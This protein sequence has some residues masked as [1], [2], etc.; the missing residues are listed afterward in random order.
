MVWARKVCVCV[1]V[2]LNRAGRRLQEP[3]IHQKQPSLCY[4]RSDIKCTTWAECSF[5]K[6][7]AA[8][9]VSS[10]SPSS[11]TSS[12]K[13]T[14]SSR[15]G[16]NLQR[17]IEYQEHISVKICV[18]LSAG[19]IQTKFPIRCLYLGRQ[20]SRVRQKS[21]LYWVRTFYWLLL[22]FLLCVCVWFFSL[23]QIPDGTATTVQSSRTDHAHVAHSVSWDKTRDHS[24][25]EY[26]TFSGLFDKN[27]KSVN[28]SRFLLPI[29]LI[30]CL[31]WSR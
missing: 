2:T 10:D 28:S 20:G 8:F 7:L 1:C 16:T 26:V 14:M 31:N 18:Y 13:L 4:N 22:Q 15:S 25:A 21:C 3:L 30:S 27:V 24:N 11:F 19:E 6:Y 29:W 9:C 5:L 12:S 17:H 23:F